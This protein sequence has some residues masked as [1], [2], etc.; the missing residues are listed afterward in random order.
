LTLWKL[1]EITL[2]I[3]L[4]EC[5]SFLFSLFKSLLFVTI[6]LLLYV[7]V[8]GPRGMRDLSSQP[9]IE[10]ASPALEDKILIAFQESSR[11]AILKRDQK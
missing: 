3:F 5:Y 6:L 2:L 9:G 8:F 4:E 11:D 7:F 1:R 10:P